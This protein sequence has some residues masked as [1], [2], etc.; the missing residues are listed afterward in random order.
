MIPGF[1]RHCFDV[2][3]VF[4]PNRRFLGAARPDLS[5]YT[6]AKH[7][8][9]SRQSFFRIVG[10]ADLLNTYSYSRSITGSTAD[11]KIMD[12]VVFIHILLILE[13]FQVDFL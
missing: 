12:L 11:F 4:V 13:G 8:G 7:E 9:R 1:I 10:L 6:T 5:V 2:S 3:I